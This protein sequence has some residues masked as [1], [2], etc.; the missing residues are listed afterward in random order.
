[1][2]E[3]NP[4]KAPPRRRSAPTKIAGH[5][6][7]RPLEGSHATWEVQGD[8]PKRLELLVLGRAR[9]GREEA[10]RT[11]FHRQLKARASLLHPHLAAIVDGGESP[12]GPYVVVSLPRAR[13]LSAEIAEGPLEPERMHT[14]LTGV[15][16][17]LDAAHTRW[18][19]H[20]DLTPRSVFVEAGA[21]EWAWLTDF[22]IA[23]NRT[24]LAFARAGYRSPEELRGEAPLPESN[25]YSLACIVYTC[26]AGT[27]PF[28]RSSGRAAMQAQLHED[29]PRLTE[30]RPELPSA[31]DDVLIAALSKTPAERPGSAG[32][33]M[34]RVGRA[35]ELVEPAEEAGRR[36]GSGRF[37]RARSNGSAGAATSETAVAT[38]QLDPPARRRL[39]PIS[40]MVRPV[41]EPVPLR[42][43]RLTPAEASRPRREA[44]MRRRGAPP[45]VLIAAL[46]L[47]VGAA[48]V[49]GWTLGGSESPKP[50]PEAAAARK[51]AA[52]RA[53]TA[54]ARERERVAWLGTAN[55]AAERLSARR[56]AHRRTLARA[57]RAHGQ[58]VAARRLAASFRSARRALGEAP[59]T[60]PQ[61]GAVDAALRRAESAYTRLA[62]SVHNGNR[63]AYRRAVASVRSAE[64]GVD[65]ALE[66][67]GSPA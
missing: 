21:R 56:A 12:R 8:D 62:R 43:T 3:R 32:E 45:A 48:G 55:A 27:A 16:D 46:V 38:I 5:R 7:L 40:Y 53:G 20:T 65:R 18:L 35:L 59:A 15:A 44:P 67:L 61:A 63:P 6:L 19:I 37:R 28:A 2:K 1:V 17:A 11:A 33:L 23:H 64:A 51:A 9:K 24:P 58:A 50:D 25:V 39:N 47:A 41:A 30:A 57:S 22:G 29:P 14:L 26:L 49:A 66:R 54:A 4:T 60:V 36:S 13:P 34:R 42:P 52:D 10:S 31:V